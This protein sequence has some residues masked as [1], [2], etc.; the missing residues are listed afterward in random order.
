MEKFSKFT[1]VIQ[2][3]IGRSKF[4]IQEFW[5]KCKE[6]F[7]MTQK[8]SNKAINQKEMAHGSESWRLDEN[9]KEI[10]RVSLVLR[11]TSTTERK[12]L[13]PFSNNLKPV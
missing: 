11:F 8:S 6:N 1:Q 5:Q 7:P 9:Y 13:V 12:F 3:V 4:K 10:S 2:S